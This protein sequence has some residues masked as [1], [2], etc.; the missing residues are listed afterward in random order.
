MV[1]CASPPPTDRPPDQRGLVGPLLLL[2]REDV[3]APPALLQHD[4]QRVAEG[5]EGEERHEAPEPEEPER[6]GER[7]HERVVERVAQPDRP[8]REVAALDARREKIL[9]VGLESVSMICQRVANRCF[10]MSGKYQASYVHRLEALGWALY[11]CAYHSA[12]RA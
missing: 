12:D 4:G 3:G 7:A 11:V 10:Q 9:G 8:R 1:H 5:D 2:L 6:V